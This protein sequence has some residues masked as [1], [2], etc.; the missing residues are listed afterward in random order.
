MGR[1]PGGGAGRL[2]AC[3]RE[4]TMNVARRVALACLVLALVLTASAAPTPPAPE[5]EVTLK[6]TSYA[7]LGKSVRALTGKVVVVDFWASWCLPC[8][9]EFPGLVRLHQ[10][11]AGQGFAAVSVSVDRPDD[12]KAR[13]SAEQFLRKQNATFANW[14]LTADA[15]EWQKKLNVDTIPAVFVFDRQNRLVKKLPVRDDKGDEKEAVDYRAIEKLVVEL[16]KK[17]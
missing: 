3:S 12:A 14:L 13:A 8:K 17:K 16:L 11:Y 15:K 6:P 4:E 10:K 5:D 1:E 7:E 9:K 2:G